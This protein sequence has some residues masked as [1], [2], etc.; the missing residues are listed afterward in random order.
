MVAAA[1]GDPVLARPGEY[2]VPLDWP[3]VVDADPDVVIAPCGYQLDGTTGL[4]ADDLV[5]RAAL[6][7]TPAAAGRVWAVDASSFFVC[8]GPR[9]I[10]GVEILAGIL[11]PD[12]WPRPS[13]ARAEVVTLVPAPPEA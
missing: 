4:A 2:S 10:D 6:S 7:R 1:G 11:H 12:A 8:P 3:T 9:L 5:L 13:G